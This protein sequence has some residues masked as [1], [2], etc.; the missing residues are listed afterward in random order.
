MFI[1]LFI[2]IFEPSR[3]VLEK[4]KPV[5]NGY[6][7]YDNTQNVKPVDNSSKYGFLKCQGINVD[8]IFFIDAPTFTYD[9]VKKEINPRF[10]VNLP[11]M[12]DG[13]FDH[14]RKEIRLDDTSN[15]IQYSVKT[16]AI[17]DMEDLKTLL[18]SSNEKIVIYQESEFR[19]N[20]ETI[21]IYFVDENHYTNQPMPAQWPKQEL[22]NNGGSWY[23]KTTQKNGDNETKKIK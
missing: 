14:S 22:I 23:M 13:K 9:L 21:R 11:I 10:R 12:S 18:H 1:P 8:N 7:Y 3:T 17:K 16:I 4:E 6:H 19:L 15:V 5:P 20:Q 2:P